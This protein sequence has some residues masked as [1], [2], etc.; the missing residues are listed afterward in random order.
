MSF[1]PA[2]NP[3]ITTPRGVPRPSPDDPRHRTD[4]GYICNECDFS[5]NHAYPGTAMGK[6]RDHCLETNH[7]V[8]AAADV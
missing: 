5:T 3:I 7:L 1:N 6:V 2:S 4:W 8:K